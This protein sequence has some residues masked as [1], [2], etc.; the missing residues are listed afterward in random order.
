[1]PAIPSPPGPALAAALGGGVGGTL[2]VHRRLG[3][4]RVTERW[5]ARC[6]GARLGAWL[7]RAAGFGFAVTA[8]TAARPL[9]DAS[10]AVLR[11]A[12]VALSWC[13][14]FAALSLAGPG[15]ARGLLEGRGLLQNHGIQPAALRAE[16]PLLLAYWSLRKLGPLVGLVL[17]GCLVGARDPGQSLRL[18][19]LG[20]GA[21]VY[22]AALG[23]G[24]GLCAH[25]C[26]RL[27]SGRGQS[28]LLGVLL[29]PELVSPAWPELPTVIAS[30]ASLLD[31][32]LGL[33]APA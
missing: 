9:P 2:G 7:G 29:L 3:R 21:L 31:I 28:L 16:R 11:L 20:A 6:R 12:L 23:A 14:G 30:Y 4:L 33:G 8:L 5:L 15:F 26:E 19:G 32:C 18:L 13:A 1:M 10:I 24:L 27:G 25:L 22:L 17:L